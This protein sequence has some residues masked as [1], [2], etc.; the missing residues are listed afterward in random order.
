MAIIKQSEYRLDYNVD[1]VF[2]VDASKRMD[3]VLSILKEG[4]NKVY[5][6]IVDEIKKRDSLNIV[7]QLRAKVIVFRKP[8][9]NGSAITET[10]F[11]NLEHESD[12]FERFMESIELSSGDCKIDTALEAL[13]AAIKSDWVKE[14]TLRRHVIMMF[15]AARDG[16]FSRE[17]FEALEDMWEVSVMEKRAKRL[18]I[19]APECSP[20]WDTNS[21]SNSFLSSSLFTPGTYLDDPDM[22]TFLIPLVFSI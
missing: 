21:W 12:E 7:Q 16:Q 20:W 1:I 5:K 6:F 22:E 15:T 17:K 2:C 8:E 14:G 19:R 3:Y 18:L 9:A 10:K 11:F 4:A 13:E